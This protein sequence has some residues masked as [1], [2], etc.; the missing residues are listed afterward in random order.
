MTE[1]D[2]CKRDVEVYGV[3]FRDLKLPLKLCRDCKNPDG[4]SWFA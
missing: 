4:G 2:F 1:C 3:V